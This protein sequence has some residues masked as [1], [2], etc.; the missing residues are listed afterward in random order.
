MF[1]SGRNLVRTRQLIMPS[2]PSSSFFTI[3]DE[4]KTD[5][6]NQNRLLLHDS[7]D[8]QIQIDRSSYVQPEGRILVWSS[9]V[10]LDLLF[11]SEKLYMDGT[12][13]TAP[14]HFDQVYIIHAIH[15]G[16]CKLFFQL[17]ILNHLIL[18]KYFSLN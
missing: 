17:N 2:L 14:P 12:F 4:Y 6:L 7:D 3:P 16:S 9:D 18:I 11:N 15:H 8:S 1:I 5:Y 13:A 10:Q